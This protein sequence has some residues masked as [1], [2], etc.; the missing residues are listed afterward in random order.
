M[1]HNFICRLDLMADLQDHGMATVRG[2][3]LRCPRMAN[4]NRLVINDS[5]TQ[6]LAVG[7]RQQFKKTA[8]EPFYYPVF[9]IW[10]PGFTLIRLCQFTLVRSAA[11]FFFWYKIRQNRKFLSPRG[12]LSTHCHFT[13][14]LCKVSSL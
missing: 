7:S 14:G 11:S 10:V 6:F 2:L 3:F 12:V 1:M 8:F 13:F 5:K 4:Y 9:E